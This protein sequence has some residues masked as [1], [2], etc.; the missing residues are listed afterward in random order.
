MK[1]SSLVNITFIIALFKFGIAQDIH[2]SQYNLSPLNLNPSLTGAFLGDLR[3]I[4]NHRNQWSSVSNPYAT[5]GFSFEKKKLFKLPISFGFQ[6]NQDRA[7]DS[8]LNTFQINPSVSYNFS[9]DSLNRFSAGAQ[10]G[11]TKQNIDYNPLY[12]DAQYNGNVYDPSLSNQENF[13][14]NNRTYLNF[15]L[16]FL[17]SIKI[18]PNMELSTGISFYNLNNSKQSYFNDNLVRLDLRSAIHSMLIWNYNKNLIFSPSLL[19]LVQGKH[20][21]FIIGTS[22]EYIFENFMQTFRSVYAGISYRGNDALLINGGYK[23]NNWQIGLNYDFNLSKL[24]PAS[25]YRGG[26]EISILYIID[27]SPTKNVIHRICPDFI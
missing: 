4:G 12:F 15:N 26:F 24:V 1:F 23:F 5:F 14:I 27:N 17:Y 6:I 3:F 25:I 21:E 18:N 7:G 20:K 11:F 2:F 8:K 16:G 9:F 19:W 13:S 10:I 22:G